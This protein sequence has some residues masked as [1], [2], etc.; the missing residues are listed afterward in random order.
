MVEAF[1]SGYKLIPRE[2]SWNFLVKLD[3]D[4]SFDADYFEKCIRHFRV[5]PT[6]G[7]GGGT[8]MQRI[9]GGAII[10]S[11]GDPPFHVRG[12]TKIYRRP[13]WEAIA[14]L[15]AGPGWDTIDEVK[16]NCVGWRTRTLTD[17]QVV[18]LKPT[19]DADGSWR[20]WYKNGRANF[21]TGYHPVF[22]VAK[23]MKRAVRRP[24]LREGLALWLGYCSGYR[25]GLVP[26]ADTATVKYLRNQQFRRLL[27]RP[28]I[29]G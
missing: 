6:L 26:L 5:D 20:N 1:N 19:G 16:A 24:L 4:L 23:C 21:L 27:L 29:Y 8:V 13:C 17:A 15:A 12:A 18:Q 9:G 25:E 10:D 3:A 22:M 7:I 28:S 14:P 11:P 2:L